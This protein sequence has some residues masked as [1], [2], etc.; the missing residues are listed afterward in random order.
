MAVYT[1]ITDEELEG[2]LADFDL[3]PPLASKGIAEGVSNSNFLLETEKGLFIL[4]VYERRVEARDLPYFLDLTHHLFEQGFPSATPV[5]DRAGRM[6]K[7]VRDKPCAIFT[8]LPVLLIVLLLFFLF[9]QQMKA[10]G[11]GAMSFGKSKARMLAPWRSITPFGLPVVPDVN[12]TSE[13]SS[14]PSA[15][16]IRLRRQPARSGTSLSGRGPKCSSGT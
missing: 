13:M 14:G 4:T 16:G 2:L 7:Q 8:F 5:E 15:S 9:R 6:L 10:A 1:D 3:G 12:I 11:R